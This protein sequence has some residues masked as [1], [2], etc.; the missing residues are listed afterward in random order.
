[1]RLQRT[2]SV[3]AVALRQRI[4]SIRDNLDGRTILLR[5]VEGIV[6][7]C[8]HQRGRLHVVPSPEASIEN[9]Q[10]VAGIASPWG[11]IL[12][13]QI[14]GTLA[15]RIVCNLHEGQNVRQRERFG[16]IKFGSRLEV[17]LAPD[18]ETRA[19]AEQKVRAG[20][21]VVASL[22]GILK[23]EISE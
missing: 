19:R 20:E 5:T 16:I 2:A 21:T 12:V 18:A 6:G 4:E 23:E 9:E 11:K 13:K 8:R 7:C 10:A 15:R 17:F 3:N 22:A 14:A 1:M